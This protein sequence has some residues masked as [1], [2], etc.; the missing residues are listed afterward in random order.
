[1]NLLHGYILKEHI[2]PFFFAFFVLMFVLVIDLM[3][4]MMKL[5]FSKGIGVL[6]ILEFFFLSLAW[7]TALAVPMAILV[8]TL[9]AFG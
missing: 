4:Q 6:T 1:M 8:A 2:G 9:M 3:L 5:L 7:M